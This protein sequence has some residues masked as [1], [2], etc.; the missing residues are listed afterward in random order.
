M[1]CATLLINIRNPQRVINMKAIVTGHAS[2][3]GLYTVKQFHQL[4]Y[5]VYGLDIKVNNILPNEIKQKRC[6]LRYEPEVKEVFKSIPNFDVA[7]NCAGVA[8][9]RKPL[10]EFS[11]SEY[12]DSFNDVFSPLFNA[13]THEINL[14]KDDMSKRRR[15]INIASIT[16]DFGAK[17]MAVYSAAKAAIVNLTKV[18][19]VEHAPHLFVNS[20]SPASIDTPMLRNKHNEKL[21]DYRQS[22]LTGDCGQEKDV[23]SVI[24]MLLKN[25]FMTGQNVKLDGGY[26]SV[27]KL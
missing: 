3:I 4:G 22:Y 26:S 6:D 14:V 23:F 25:D 27:F 19:A 2:G 11:L 17:N 1:Q 10:A 15:I 21:P 16:A 24:E 5:E 18:A 13:L 12:Q 7:V 20:I 8:G 9:L